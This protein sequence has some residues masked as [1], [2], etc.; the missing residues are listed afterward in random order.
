MGE[1]GIYENNP[2]YTIDKLKDNSYV[3]LINVFTNKILMLFIKIS[4]YSRS[5]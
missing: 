1:Y 4:K 5:N 2:K 3:R